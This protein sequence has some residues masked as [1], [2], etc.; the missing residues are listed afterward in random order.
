MPGSK[1][2]KFDLHTHTPASKA[3]F[4]GQC[5]PDEWLLGHMRAGID[6]VGITDH[7]SGEWIDVLSQTI[8]DPTFQTHPAYR[9]IHIFPGVELSTYEGYH[10]LVLF[11]L[12][13]GTADIHSFID[14]V[15]YRGEKGLSDKNIEM[16]IFEVIEEVSKRNGLIIPAH[17]DEKNGFFIEWAKKELRPLLECDQII[18]MELRNANYQLP[19]IYS[20]LG[21]NWT[22]ILGSDCH[23]PNAD[24]FPGSHFTWVKMSN[25]S[26]D[27]LRLAL[28]DGKLSIRRSDEQTVDPNTVHGNSQIKSIKIAEAVYIG[29]GTPFELSFS[30]WLNC[31]VGGRGTGKSTLLEFI[32]IALMRDNELPEDL[33]KELTKYCKVKTDRLDDGLLLENSTFEVDYEKDGETFKII[34]QQNSGHLSILQLSDTGEWIVTEGVIAQRFPIS[35][36]SQKQIY[37]LARKPRALLRIID[38]SASVNY[39]SWK[40]EWNSTV[41]KYIEIKAKVRQLQIKIEEESR[42]KGELA[43]VLRKIKLFEN[44]GHADTLKK[45]QRCLQI[46]T[47]I[48]NWENYWNTIG[49]DLRSLK[50]KINFADL[51]FDE[52]APLSSAETGLIEHSKVIK[53]KLESI[54][55]EI[56]A[57]ATKTEECIT[58]WQQN[59]KYT[60]WSVEH[61]GIIETYELLKK[62]LE[63]EGVKDSNEYENLVKDRQRVEKEIDNINKVKIELTGKL[64][65]ATTILTELKKLRKNLT[66]KRVAFLQTVLN[67]NQHVRINVLPYDDKDNVEAEFR[68]LIGKEDNSFSGDIG[69]PGK[70][71]GL[72]GNLYSNGINLKKDNAEAINLKVIDFESRLDAMKVRIK[73]IANGSINDLQDRRFGSAITKLSAESFDHID[74]WYPEDSLGVEYCTTSAGKWRPIAE[75]SPGQKTAALLAFLF[76]YG[77]EPLLLDQP[78]DDLDNQLIYDLIVTQLREIKRNRQV[79][80]VSHNANIVVNGDAELV[81]SLA[82]P[83]GRSAKSC[84][85]GLQEVNVRKEVCTVMEGGADAFRQRY[86]RIHGINSILKS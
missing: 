52:R 73:E 51:N 66:Q 10:A 23:F 42:L 44:T 13:K 57:L 48:E 7:N 76:S 50:T 68:K 49:D 55:N 27:G 43:D 56:D 83:N 38:E 18:A 30:P 63:E 79:I 16:D 36:Y 64:G 67:N 59:G 6:C 71:E 39:H 69:V 65:E 25:P 19:G 41:N 81:V 17:V 54:A 5:K 2:W 46:A 21:V 31:I 47:A 33:Q 35:V 34:W 72:L 15:K 22:M 53:Q 32:R 78:E 75:G 20:E 26:L 29:R 3:C 45:Y 8:A 28:F 37:E 77:K 1:W 85:G 74:C 60:E 82:S 70:P 11:D 86:H 58:E 80:I 14:S 24:R 4:G 12:G 62:K 9:N 84:N 61:K 40:D